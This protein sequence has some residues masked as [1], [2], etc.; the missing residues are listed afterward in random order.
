ME[1]IDYLKK[2]TAHIK[3]RD[4][5]LV[6]RFRNVTTKIKHRGHEKGPPV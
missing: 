2:F 3:V 1:K 6:G 4:E 5:I